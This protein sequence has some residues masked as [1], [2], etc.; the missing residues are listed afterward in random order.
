MTNGIRDD[1]YGN[2][3]ISLK[4][5]WPLCL[6]NNTKSLKKRLRY[7]NQLYHKPWLT[8]WGRVT[9]ICIGKLTINGSDNGLWP[10][11]RQAIIR[12]NAGILLIGTLGTNFSE[13]LS[14]IHTFS[15][16]KMLSGRWRPF[17]LGLKYNPCTVSVLK[18]RT[19]CHAQ[20]MWKL[21]LS[22]K[23]LHLLYPPDL[24]N[25][26][27]PALLRDDKSILVHITSLRN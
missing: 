16:K 5:L 21:T 23:Q 27:G 6:R 11:R 2:I 24:W 7:K 26:P 13:I 10:C 9:H 19:I 3:S 20:D 8:H 4:S 17:C 18:I 1:C 22:C 15:L 25:L 12:T 14:E